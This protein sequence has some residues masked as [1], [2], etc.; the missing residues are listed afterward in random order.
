MSSSSAERVV[1][2]GGAIVGSFCAWELRRAGHTGPITVI[3]KDMSY[4]R[5]S[6]ALSAASIRTQF[7]TPTS[8]AMSLHAVDLFRDLAWHLGDDDAQ[9]GY[10]ESGY[11]IL[12]TPEQVVERVAAAE[13][14]RMHGADVVALTGDAL[15]SRFPQLDFHGVGI[16]TLGLS[17]EGWFDAWSLLSVVKRA[18]RRLGVEYLEAAASGFEISSDAVTAVQLASG[19]TLACDV[20]VLA[21]GALSGRVAALAGID[22]PVVPKKRSVFNFQAP[23]SQDG[24][25]MLFDTSG[26]WVRPEGDGFIGGIQ[27]AA[28]DDPDADDDFDPHHDLFEEVYWPLLVQRI[29]EMDKLRL[30]RSWAGHYEVNLLDHNAIIGPHDQLHNLLFA[31]GFSGHGVMHAPAAGRGIAEIITTGGYTTIDLTP[32]GWDRIRD[33]RPMFETIVY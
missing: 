22:L 12:G 1:I 16:G 32:F 27:P 6:T 13:M 9:I 15:V 20:C 3:D 26:I 8:I 24:F 19:E 30:R 31:T 17:G 5:S 2:V 7:G 11:L 33:R 18:A 25:P 4:E 21:A 14:Q 29:P 23:V 10:V 28:H